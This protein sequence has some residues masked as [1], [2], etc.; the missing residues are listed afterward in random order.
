MTKPDRTSV[1]RVLEHARAE[2]VAGRS[3]VAELL[4]RTVLVVQPQHPGALAGLADLA[5]AAQA[6]AQPDAKAPASTKAG[7]DSPRSDPTAPPDTF[8]QQD[9]RGAA[10]ARSGAL[11]EQ[12]KRLAGRFLAGD[13]TGAET[14]ALAM[15][16]ARPEDAFGWKLLGAARQRLGNAQGAFAA[17]TRATELLP[18][19]AE[20]WFNL[21][22]AQQT[23]L[24]LAGAEAAYRRALDLKPDFAEAAGNLGNVLAAQERQA[25]AELCYRAALAVKPDYAEAANNLGV[26]LHNLGR[27]SEAE[28]ACRHAAAIRPDYAEA[29]GN[30][31]NVLMDMNQLAEAEACHRKSL[32]LNPNQPRGW[33]NLGVALHRQKRLDEARRCLEHALSLWPGNPETL[34]NLGNVLLDQN[35]PGEAEA[36]FRLALAKAPDYARAHGNLGVALHTQGR[37]E[38]AFAA[39]RRA[40]ELA[41]DN[42]EA[43]SNL[44]ALLRALGRLGSARELCREAVDCDPRCAAARNN[45]GVVLK[46]CGALDEAV[47]CFR[48]AL[49]LAPM[50]F[51]A[52][53]NL[54]YTLHYAGAAAAPQ[55]LAEAR[56]Y[57]AF[58]ARAAG[59]AYTSWLTEPL[60]DTGGRLRVGLVSGDLRSHAVGYFLESVLD[61]LDPARLEL[62]AYPSGAG[63]AQEGGPEADGADPLA[64]RLRG[65]FA[66]WRPL[67]RCDAEAA[68]LI[69]AD[70]VHVLV[71]LSGHTAHNRLPVFARRPAPAQATWLG[72]AGATGLAEMDCLLADPVSLPPELEG[73]CTETVLRLPDT[74]LCFTPPADSPAPAPLPALENGHVT[75]CCCNDLAKLNDAVLT[76]WARVLAA[77]PGSRL[78]LKAGQLDD[79]TLREETVERVASLGL[80][81]ARVDLCGPQPRAEYLAAYARADIALDPFPYPGGATSVEALWMGVPVLTLAGRGFLARQGMALLACAGLADWVAQDEDAYVA[82]AAARAADIPALAALRG[83][84]RGQVAASPLCD[85]ARFARNMEAAL[86]EIWRRWGAPRTNGG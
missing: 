33:S 52:R 30:L 31:G 49:A 20:A 81:P 43:A 62:Y 15:T 47:E 74:R 38:E 82:L 34:N 3:E 79:A 76:L 53:S 10:S 37:T 40:R 63:G 77:V 61:N 39:F 21:G 24:R 59:E 27:L 54:L 85:A 67:P 25:E 72:Y 29:H 55:R 5:S 19:D 14:D 86:L 45:L 23:L 75:F 78:L 51:E 8:D 46:E 35:L 2:A 69:H 64:A 16:Q 42:A 9:L 60:A 56:E 13:F 4:Y 41:P 68:E 7:G 18:D 50:D 65:R 12:K 48:Q 70:G 17:N 6:P 1:G 71:D 26:A 73:E 36:D 66:A 22:V 80:D 58:A 57:G 84:L 32:A 11:L 83:R 28:T 44:G